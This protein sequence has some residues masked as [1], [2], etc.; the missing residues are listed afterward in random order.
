MS[1]IDS[2]LAEL[3]ERTIAQRVGIRHDEFRMHYAPSSNIVGSFDE[4]ESIIADYYA[5]HSSACISHGG[6]LP[7]FEAMSRAKELLEREY[8]RRGGTMMTAYNDGHDGTNGGMRAVLDTIAEALKAESLGMYIRD[9]FDR[10]VK[11][12]SW[13]QKVEIIRQFIAQCGVHLGSSIRT[14]QP[15]SY[16]HDYRELIQAYKTAL[17]KT[18]STFRRI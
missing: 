16:A 17:E 2:L 9:V 11:P 3:D 10:Y 5:K 12:D 4:F 14:H 8:R 1:S 6:T 13:E 7:R 18:S 15:E